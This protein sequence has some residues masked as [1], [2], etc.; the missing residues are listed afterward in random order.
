MTPSSARTVA[1]ALLA[2]CVTEHGSSPDAVSATLGGSWRNST[3]TAVFDEDT[4]TMTWT[5]GT[6]M[7]TGTWSLAGSELDLS[8]A[9]CPFFGHLPIRVDAKHLLIEHVMTGSFLA[10]SGSSWTGT[11]LERD[12]GCRGELARH[13]RTVLLDGPMVEVVDRV[14]CDDVIA[15]NNGV[16]TT[17]EWHRSEDGFFMESAG[18]FRSFFLIAGGLS[19]SRW[20]RVVTPERGCRAR[21]RARRWRARARTSARTT[22]RR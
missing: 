6:L 2:G 11:A 7:R 15:C 1:V 19:K 17:G 3:E 20:T 12:L 18:D 13:T 16:V 4:H 14:C 10:V 8:C 22:P 21:P 9:Q 5:D